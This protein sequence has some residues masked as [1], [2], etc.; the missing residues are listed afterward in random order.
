MLFADTCGNTG[1]SGFTRR[2]G[3]EQAVTVTVDS[4]DGALSTHGL[5]PAQL[6][7][8]DVEG[9]EL[10]VMRGGTSLLGSSHPP[11]IMF[12]FVDDLA[13]R[14]GTTFAEIRQFLAAFG[15]R[16]YIYRAGRFAPCPDTLKGQHDVFAFTTTQ[17]GDARPPSAGKS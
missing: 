11:M 12:E 2:A 7:K 17:I 15:Y 13:R 3:A 9:Y 5:P 8:I 6:L 4:L 14:A 16:L 1:R 10:D